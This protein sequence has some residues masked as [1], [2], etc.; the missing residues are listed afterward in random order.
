MTKPA[1]VGPVL[2]GRVLRSAMAMARHPAIVGGQES[3]GCPLPW[4][5]EHRQAT[6]LVLSCSHG[7]TIAHKHPQK[8]EVDRT[9][10]RK[11]RA[12]RMDMRR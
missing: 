3:A 11:F 2:R 6:W 9:F 5:G 1:T 4:V 12:R 7:F 8:P 10:D